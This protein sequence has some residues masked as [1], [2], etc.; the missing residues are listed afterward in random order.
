MVTAPPRVRLG[1]RENAGQFGMLVLINGFVGAMLGIE[2]SILPLLAEREFAVAARSAMLSFIVV[3]GVT[4]ALANL[5]AGR[6]A[7]RWGR[8]R[9]LV[10]GWAAGIPVPFMLMWAPDWQWVI[11]ANALLGVSQGLTWST[12]IIMKIDLVGRRDRG[13]A[14]GLNECAGYVAL[15]AS[16]LLTAWIADAYA[17]TPHPFYPGVVYVAAGLVLS[18]VVC[19]DTRAHVEIE[20]MTA[21]RPLSTRE[22]FWRTSLRDRDLS[23][24]TQ[25]GLVNNL[26]DGIAWGLFPL[27]YAA[28]G[29]N[30]TRI[31]VLAALYP[32][33][34]GVT[35]LLT[36]WA[37]DHL[38]RKRLI[39]WGMWGQ[40][41]AIGLVAMSGGFNGYAVAAVAL[42]IG[43]AM[44][45][46]TLLAA[47][48]DGADASWRGTAIGVYRWW[49]DLGYAVGA[50]AA[51]F[52]ADSF[53]LHWAIWITAA[54]TFVS[55]TV[56]AIRLQETSH[57][58]I[59]HRRDLA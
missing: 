1:L 52:I 24:V 36:G 18:A 22:I 25:A 47:I 39:V 53:G 27:V 23:T 11:Y 55:G 9:V 30:L 51:G 6:L 57:D 29:L 17:I 14:L 28:A 19:R 33:I 5:A 26:N 59:H 16:A 37:S 54:A 45:Y 50:L 56:A 8:K 4:K 38:G 15:A 10:S 58:T 35:Q 20:T 46:P 32:A 21:G 13:L 31:G 49:R 7:D 2:R 43:T 42:G 34:W 40:A 44:V 12:T 3:F 48:S 41:G